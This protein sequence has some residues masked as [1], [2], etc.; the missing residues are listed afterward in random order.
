MTAKIY[1]AR[2]LKRRRRSNEELAQLDEQILAVLREDHP[3]SVRHTFYMMKNPRLPVPVP[4]SEHGYDLVQRRVLMLRRS[5]R[6]PY[7]WITDA[8]RRGYFVDTFKSPSDFLSRVNGLYRADL[9]EQTN[10][11]V[12]VWAESRSI[13]GVIQEDCEELAVPLYPSGGFT[14]ATL[15][16]EAAQ[17][18]NEVY[19]GRTVKIFYIGDY[20]Q[21]GVLIDKAIESELRTHLDDDIEMDFVRVGIN[22]EQIAI[23]DLPEKPR[24][25]TDRRSPEVEVTVEAEAMPAHILRDLLRSVIEQLLPRD[26]LRIARIAEESERAGL[27]ILSQAYRER[28]R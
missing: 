6:L 9:W 24:K 10:Y 18:I 12:E 16:H 5:G 26:A 1:Q 20:D 13:A 28:G 3:Q 22:R 2:P 7:G 27:E 23:Y 8:T 17:H 15:A 14:S 21:S 4:K 11:Y 25:A 19:L